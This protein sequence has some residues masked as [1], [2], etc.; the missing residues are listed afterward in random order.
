MFDF[1]FQ[2]SSFHTSD[3]KKDY[4]IH[5]LELDQSQ[6]TGIPHYANKILHNVTSK[7]YYPSVWADTQAFLQST[8]NAYKTQWQKL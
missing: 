3:L 2:D 6:I 8:A 1:H 4:V 5:A 7:N